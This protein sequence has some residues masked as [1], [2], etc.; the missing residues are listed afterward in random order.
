MDDMKLFSLNDLRR[1]WNQMV[2]YIV[3]LAMIPEN[4]REAL[5]QFYIDSALGL[6]QNIEVK[7]SDY[8]P[9]DIEIKQEK[10]IVEKDQDVV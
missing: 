3:P 4:Q 2:K 5:E 9:I 8:P 7:P 6:L 10:E 1:L